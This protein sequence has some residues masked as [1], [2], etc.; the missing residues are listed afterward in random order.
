MVAKFELSDDSVVV[1]IGTGA[2]GGV[3]ANELAQK[4]VKV[5]ALEA[6]GRYLPEDYIN[7]E[8]DSFGQLA[9]TEP[10]TT[11]G[12]WRVSKDFSGLPAWIV[13]AVGGTSIHWAGASLRFQEHEFKAK[14][15]YGDVDGANLL[16]WPIDP[17]ELAPYYDKAEAKLGVT[18][19][20]GRPG[21][22]GSNNFKVLEKGAKALG[23]KEVNTGHMAI[24]SV[25][26]DDRMACQQ[27]GFCFQGCKW[28][29][30]WSSAYTDI[31]R[32]EAT[33][34]LEVRDHSHVARIVHDDKGRASGVE[35]FDQDGNLQMQKAK[36]VCVAG[37]SIESPRVLLNSHSSMFPDGLANSSGQVGRNYMRHTTGSVYG[38]FDKP[39]RMW[40][41][42]TMAGIIRDESRHDPSR[43]FV[44]GYELETLSLGLPFMA[45]FLDPGSWGREFTSALDDYENMAGM[46]IVGEDMPQETNRITLNHGV[47]DAYGLPVANVN[48]TDHPNDRAMRDHAYARG[49]AIYEA[50]GATRTLPTPPYPSTHNLGTNRMSE[51]P[52]DGVVN[53][54]GQAHDVPNLFVSDGSQFTT[55][56]SENPTLTIVALAIRQADFISNEMSKGNI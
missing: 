35:Y 5:V 33:G 51:R 10:R 25:E 11:S 50:V 21:L 4:G 2:G 27:T 3:L 52:R 44:G 6:G 9:W 22:P 8:W 15:H 31:P 26:Y 18:R 41:G 40:R 17:A 30:K 56:A 7:D 24:N 14:T 32:G 20:G 55:G 12:D 13:K 49:K 37:N 29:A 43:G 39:V 54:H 46:W 48:Y 23:Y 47:K 16:D 34:N 36:I 19:T 53:M 42:T 1:I 45:A 28:G 38:V